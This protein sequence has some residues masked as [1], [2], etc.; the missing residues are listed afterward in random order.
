MI[1]TMRQARLVKGITQQDM[2][3]KLNVHVDT[4]RKM[5][6]HPD[7]VTIGNAKKISNLLGISYDQIFFNDYSTLSRVNDEVGVALEM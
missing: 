6:K 1:F 3:Q 2:A 7:R 4:Y 5:E